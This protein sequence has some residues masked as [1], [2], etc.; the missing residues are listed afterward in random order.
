MASRASARAAAGPRSAKRIDDWPEGGAVGLEYEGVTI[1]AD[2]CQA[3]LQDCTFINCRFANVRF[4]CSTNN[5]VTFR[6]CRFAS[7][8][9]FDATFTGCAVVGSRFDRCDF[10]G[11]KVTGGDWSDVELLGADL[12]TADRPP[13][14]QPTSPTSTSSAPCTG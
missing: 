8:N 7:C 5:N 6:E 3:A 1:S 4:N 10:S 11:L 2:L 9:F 12:G 13:R 14:R